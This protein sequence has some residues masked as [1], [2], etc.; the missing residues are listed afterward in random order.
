MLAFLRQNRPSL[1]LIGAALVLFAALAPA[2]MRATAS[3]GSDAS[4]LFCTTAGLVSLDA[5]NADLPERDS[6]K[7]AQGEH[8]PLCR[9]QDQLPF[10][11]EAQPWSGWSALSAPVQPTPALVTAKRVAHWS[12]PP[13]HGPPALP[14][15][16]V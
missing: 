7:D 3:P 4:A 6:G 12:L 10:L 14:F 2:M 15:A 9:L 16:Q 5:G 1:G 11:P 13:S 8:C